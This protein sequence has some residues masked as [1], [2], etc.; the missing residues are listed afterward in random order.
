MPIFLYFW[1]IDSPGVFGGT[2]KLAWPRGPS[3]GST[4]RR[5]HGRLAM[6]PLVIQDF[7]PFKVQVSLASS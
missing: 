4:E 6:P 2:M 3:S 1:P 5:R 7:V